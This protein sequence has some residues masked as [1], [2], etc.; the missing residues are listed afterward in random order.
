MSKDV[1]NFIYCL[2][3]HE[4]W[5]EKR[6]GNECIWGQWPDEIVWTSKR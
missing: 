1:R 3:S 2:N 5:S 4:E 6:V